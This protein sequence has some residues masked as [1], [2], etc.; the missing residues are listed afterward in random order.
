MLELARETDFEAVN[1]IARQVTEHHAQW[2]KGLQIVEETYPK[3]FFLE[4][5]QADSIY[6][7]AIFVARQNGAV[8]GYMRVYLWETNSTVTEKRCMLSIDDLGVEESLRHQG[9]GTKM[10]ASLRVMA[11]EWGVSSLCLYVDAP[12][13]SAQTFYKKCG[14]QVMNLGMRVEI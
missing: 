11:K 1:R 10:M 13:E 4:C 7:N 9:I 5:I 3:E 8:V 12:N 6:R 2:D 14:F